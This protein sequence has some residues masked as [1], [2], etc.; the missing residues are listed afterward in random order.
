LGRSGVPFQPSLGFVRS[1]FCGFTGSILGLQLQE[2]LLGSRGVQFLVPLVNQNPDTFLRGPD[3]IGLSAYALG[4]RASQVGFDAHSIG[5]SAGT[6]QLVT[7]CIFLSPHAVQVGA[8][9]FQDPHVFHLARRPGVPF[10]QFELQDLVLCLQALDP[11]EQL[12]ALL[13]DGFR[14]HRLDACLGS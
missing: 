13:G 11:F 5:L 7:H 12:R 8:V 3:A 1:V 4:L 6:I 10:G 14:M 2:D 9:Q